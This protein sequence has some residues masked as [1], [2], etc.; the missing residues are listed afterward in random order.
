MTWC[1]GKLMT[2]TSHGQEE[3]EES[4][5]KV[6]GRACPIPGIRK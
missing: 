4:H 5:G 1:T 6:N 3:E 2:I